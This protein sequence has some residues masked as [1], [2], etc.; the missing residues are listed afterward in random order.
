MTGLGAEQET[1]MTQIAQMDA[2]KR[3]FLLLFSLAFSSA[4]SA[5]V[6]ERQE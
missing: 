1:Q 6:V 4:S 5:F 3:A 2:D